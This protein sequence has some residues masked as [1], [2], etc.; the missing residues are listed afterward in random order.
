MLHH[1]NIRLCKTCCG[2]AAA[3]P[4][5]GCR[6]A[7][8]NARGHATHE[9][10]DLRCATA[11]DLPVWDVVS[12]TATREGMSLHTPHATAPRA[13]HPLAPPPRPRGIIVQIRRT[14]AKLPKSYIF[15]TQIPAQIGHTGEP[16][17]DIP[18]R[19]GVHCSPIVATKRPVPVVLA[20]YDTLR[21]SQSRHHNGEHH[22][23]FSEGR[24]GAGRDRGACAWGY[25]GSGPERSLEKQCKHCDYCR[26]IFIAG[27]YFCYLL[28]GIIS[29]GIIATHSGTLLLYFCYSLRD[30]NVPHG[31]M[32]ATHS[33]TLLYHMVLFL[34]LTQG[35]YYITG[36]YFCYSLR[37]KYCCIRGVRSKN[38]PYPEPPPPPQTLSPRSWTGGGGHRGSTKTYTRTSQGSAGL[39][40]LWYR[41]WTPRGAQ[42]CATTHIPSCRVLA[43]PTPSRRQRA[44]AKR[45]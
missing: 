7:H 13:P 24:V 3:C 44:A 32:S 31:I 6:I 8:G 10:L 35:H 40:R 27:Q 43:L 5:M 4:G 23:L 41:H 2:C 11:Q 26:T 18:L 16:R 28:R 39:D 37:D 12:R 21:A 30:I 17:M 29:Q 9:F 42:V 36:Y 15:E 38:T 14:T 20:R 1:A 33:G 22:T 25:G 19:L 45:P 34:L